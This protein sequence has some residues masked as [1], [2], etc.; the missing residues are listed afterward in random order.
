MSSVGASPLAVPREGPPTVAVGAQAPGGS[1]AASGPPH[2]PE[3]MV[4]QGP[5]GVDFLCRN[6]LDQSLSP[7]TRGFIP[8][9]RAAAAEGRDFHG[10]YFPSEVVEA[11]ARCC[12]IAAIAP[13]P[14]ASATVDLAGGERG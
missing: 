10:L 7:Y 1:P 4:M 14:M 5:A 8:L 13:A 3:H 12:G 2:F 9:L 11:A 6:V